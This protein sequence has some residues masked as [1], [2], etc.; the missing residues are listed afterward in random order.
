MRIHGRL[1]GAFAVAAITPVIINGKLG[2]VVAHSVTAYMPFGEVSV[3]PSDYTPVK[4]VYGPLVGRQDDIFKAMS[5]ATK[6]SRLNP[7]F[8][9][10]AQQDKTITDASTVAIVVFDEDNQ[11][12]VGTGTIIKG[13]DGVSNILTAGHVIHSPWSQLMEDLR[14]RLPDTLVSKASPPSIT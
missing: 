4:D 11:A 7:S 8:R 3:V 13:E 1:L 14:R 5:S 9:P 12:T 10:A 2:D 6:V